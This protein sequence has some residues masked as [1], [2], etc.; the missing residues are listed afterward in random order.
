[1]SNLFQKVT[2]DNIADINILFGNGDEYCIAKEYIACIGFKFDTII[3][4]F[5]G[6][7]SE[8]R[9][10]VS[11]HI[12]LKPSAA[13]LEVKGYNEDVKPFERIVK[14]PDID[15]ICIRFNDNQ[16]ESLAIAGKDAFSL[17]IED[18]KKRESFIRA[19][20]TPARG[21]NVFIKE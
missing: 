12:K 9:Q 15:L 5:K 11:G 13:C 16:L 3:S 20:I 2:L 10:I 4:S 18:M 1:M 6:L 7:I 17:N 19:E 21:L 8:Y 14:N